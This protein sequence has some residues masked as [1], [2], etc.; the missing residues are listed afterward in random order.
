MRFKEEEVGGLV[1]FFVCL[2]FA[3]GLYDKFVHKCLY[4]YRW[5]TMFPTSN[6][7]ICYRSKLTNNYDV[8]FR[9]NPFFLV[10]SWLCTP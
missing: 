1:C 2:P 4:Y 10:F 8:F 9:V 3:A 5:A 7:T 6:T